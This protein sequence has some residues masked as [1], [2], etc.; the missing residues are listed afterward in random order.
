MRRRALRDVR[1]LAQLVDRNRRLMAVRHRPDDVLRAERGIAAE[2]HPRMGATRWWSR[3]PPA[4]SIRRNRCRYRARSRGR[5]SP[6]R[7]RPA[8]R[9]IRRTGPARRSA[10]GGGASCRR[11]R[12][13]TFSKVMPTS[14]PS[15]W[16]KS[17][18]TRK[19]RIGMSSC[20]ASSFSQGDAFISSKPE[21][22]ITFTSSP[23]RRREERQQSIAVLP[24]PSTITRLPMLVMW[25][26]DTEDSQSM[27]IWMFAA[28]SCRPGNVQIAPARRAGADEDRVVVLR[29]QRLQAVDALAEPHLETQVGDIADFFVDHLLRQA[30]FRDLA[31]DHTAGARIGVVHHTVIAKRGKVARHGQRRRTGTDQGNALA[32][33]RRSRSRQAIANVAL[34]VGGDAL[35]P[36]DRH[37]FLLDAATPAGRLARPVAGPPE[38]P[39]EHVGAPVDHVGVGIPAGGDETDVFRHRRVRRTRALAIHDLVEVLRVPN[40]G[41]LQGGLLP[42]A[43]LLPAAAASTAASSAAFPLVSSTGTLPPI[44]GPINHRQ[45]AC[46]VSAEQ[47]RERQKAR[48]SPRT[49]PRGAARHGTIGNPA[50]GE[51]LEPFT[52]SG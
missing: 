39:R 13:C 20:I 30:E 7:P 10:P 3:R 17:F 37:R 33:V 26:K 44:W 47:P 41:R 45:C 51:P 6:A 50:K 19:F 48:A 49:P 38:N 43:R 4:C 9:R 18:G 25:P 27:P 52:G 22:T 24:P 46:C 8:R 34:V 36:A 15:S 35:Q 2:E 28:A 11:T 31:A 23:P 42:P 29:Q 5:R 1:A 14:L 12:P 16:M 32:I 21:R 40:I